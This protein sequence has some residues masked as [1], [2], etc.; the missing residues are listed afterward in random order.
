MFTKLYFQNVHP[1]S[2]KHAQKVQVYILSENKVSR[3]YY[4]EKMLDLLEKKY[5]K[6]IFINKCKL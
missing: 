5:I 6:V 1:K 2:L 4:W 3:N